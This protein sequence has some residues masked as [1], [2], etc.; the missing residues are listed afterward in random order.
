MSILNIFLSKKQITRKKEHATLKIELNRINKAKVYLNEWSDMPIIELYPEVCRILHIKND[1][2]GRRFCFN[3]MF[4]D[5][6]KL[7]Y[8]LHQIRN[9]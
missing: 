8:K 4:D 3:V 6:E 9:K 7:A 1:E 2:A 5:A